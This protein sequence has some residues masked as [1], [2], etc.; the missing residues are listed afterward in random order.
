MVGL[1]FFFLFPCLSPDDLFGLK[2]AWLP[3]LT[4]LGRRVTG[5]H[6]LLKCYNLYLPSN[7]YVL[8][9][10]IHCNSLHFIAN[11]Y[12]LLTMCQKLF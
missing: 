8:M 2:W 9:L 11:T 1:R 4:F 3:K 6:N 12:I 5:E 10:V 7:V